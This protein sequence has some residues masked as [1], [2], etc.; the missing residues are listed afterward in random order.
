M[1]DK[2]VSA[3]SYEKTKIIIKRPERTGYG[4]KSHIGLFH[5]LFVWDVYGWFQEHKHRAEQ[6]S[7]FN[8]G[9]FFQDNKRYMPS[10]ALTK[11]EEWKMKKEGRTNDEEWK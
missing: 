5:V 3:E 1:A 9:I 10:R 6:P 7:R 8:T 2:C 11:N 4:V